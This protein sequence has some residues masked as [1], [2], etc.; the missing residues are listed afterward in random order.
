MTI[1]H[2]YLIK[3]EKYL[4][5]RHHVSQSTLDYRAELVQ[6]LLWQTTYV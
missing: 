1:K 3:H 6:S 2:E 5:S 4:T